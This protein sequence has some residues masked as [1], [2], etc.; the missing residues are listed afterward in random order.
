MHAPTRLKIAL[1]SLLSRAIRFLRF[2]VGKSSNA[3]IVERRGITWKLDLAEGFDFSIYLFGLIEPDT[4]QL[5]RET[6]KNGMTVIDIGANIGAHA[7]PLA[8]S[9]GPGG[10]VVAVEPTSWAIEKLREN[11]ELNPTLKESLRPVQAMLGDGST[12]MPHSF[13]A[14]WSLDPQKEETHSVHRGSL[15]DAETAQETTLDGLVAELGLTQVDVIKLDVDGFEPQVLRGSEKTLRDSQPLIVMEICLYAHSQDGSADDLFQ[16]LASFNYRFYDERSRKELPMT[17]AAL[18]KIIP[19]GGG[20]NVL[21]A[22][23]GFQMEQ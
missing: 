16:Y 21:V 23:E 12:P 1:A 18:S 5:L 10:Q 7:L 22:P 4:S 19:E 2:C 3:V 15:C 14:R 13:Y 17:E 8:S 11:L 6:V 20:I 9:V